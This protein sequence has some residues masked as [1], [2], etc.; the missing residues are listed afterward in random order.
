MEQ[1][2]LLFLGLFLILLLA[3]KAVVVGQLP[4]VDLVE[5]LANLVTRRGLEEL[6]LQVAKVVVAQE[7]ALELHQP[8]EL[9]EVYILVQLVQMD[10][11]PR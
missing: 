5:E 7:T 9:L 1:P 6:E 11:R 4:Q 2:Q 3:E 10:H 8:P